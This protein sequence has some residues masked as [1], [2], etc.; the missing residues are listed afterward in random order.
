MSYRFKE[1]INNVDAKT[2]LFKQKK[3]F[4]ATALREMVEADIE[5]IEQEDSPV[6]FPKAVCEKTGWI[7][8]VLSYPWIVTL[9]FI[10]E[11]LKIF[12]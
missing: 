12:E 10:P 1:I 6:L 2:S 3:K 7:T 9:L 8:G 11:I 4:L 5:L